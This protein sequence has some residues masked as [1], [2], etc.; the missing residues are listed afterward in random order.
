[1]KSLGFT[2]EE[3]AALGVIDSFGVIDTKTKNERFTHK[4]TNDY[5]KNLLSFGKAS[6]DIDLL[7]DQLLLKDE[8]KE[9]VKKFADDEKE[10]FNV[11]EKAF[12]KTTKI[13]CDPK[14]LGG[15]E[16]FFNTFEIRNP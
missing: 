15:V 11:F 13:G 10:F 6:K 8:Y 5:Y 2:N 7:G 14:T 9:S 12:I 3:I 4:F 16:D 1:M